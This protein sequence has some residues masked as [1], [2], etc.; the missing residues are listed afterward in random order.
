M[1]DSCYRAAAAFP[2]E[3][4]E[5][6]LADGM[7]SPLD[8]LQHIIGTNHLF[9]AGFNEQREMSSDEREEIQARFSDF[10]DAL[11]E[12]KRSSAE[13]ITAIENVD[14]ELLF[15]DGEPD[16]SRGSWLHRLQIAS[17]HMVY[18]WGQLNYIQT[19]YGDMVM[20]YLEPST[21]GPLWRYH[22]EVVSARWA[23]ST[24]SAQTTP[25]DEGAL[26]RKYSRNSTLP[27]G[28]LNG[29]NVAPWIE[30]FISSSMKWAIS[31]RTWA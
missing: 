8:I 6:K 20:H 28:P 2:S 26:L 15:K 3:K 27:A 24:S 17:V 21:T 4:R 9:I 18:H 25:V 30:S 13:L 23:S 14:P 1:S 10:D 5:L 7:A 12:L 31:S 11:A 16:L 22:F 19:S 29:E